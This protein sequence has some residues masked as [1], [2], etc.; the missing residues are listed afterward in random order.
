M[1]L[2]FPRLRC[3]E[4]GSHYVVFPVLEL[5]LQTRLALNSEILLLCFLGSEIK[6]M[7]QHSLD[8]KEIRVL[9]K[10]LAQVALLITSSELLDDLPCLHKI[11][12]DKHLLT[13]KKG[14]YLT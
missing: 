2:Y 7:H 6:G 10:L 14:I 4:T 8:K 9:K 13:M 12:L 11:Q 5:A 3:F 1:K